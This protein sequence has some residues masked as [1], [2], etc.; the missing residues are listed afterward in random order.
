MLNYFSRFFWAR[1][2]LGLN[3]GF[4]ILTGLTLVF[5]PGFIAELMLTKEMSW[6]TGAFIGL[7]VVLLVFAIGLIALVRDRYL[8]RPKIIS[9]SAA[10]VGWVVSSCVVLLLFNDF[11]TIKGVTIV[12]GVNVFVAI[13]AV[14]Q[15]MGT[16]VTIAA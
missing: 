13:F 14:G 1:V 2:F 16:R 6:I 5:F 12:L 4:S 15:F 7:G 10:D 8:S 9:I 3:A 11:L